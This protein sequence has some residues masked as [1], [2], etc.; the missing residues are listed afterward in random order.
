MPINLIYEEPAH[1]SNFEEDAYLQA[2]LD[3][4]A[5]VAAGQFESGWDHFV[6]F[7]HGE[8][9][10]LAFPDRASWAPELRAARA[11]K[12]ERFANA[13][14]GEHDAWEGAVHATVRDD[15]LGPVVYALPAD[16][17]S[18]FAVTHAPPISSWEYDEHPLSVINEHSDGLVLDCGAGFRRRYFENVINLEIVPYTSTDVVAVAERI[19]LSDGTV[20][21]VICIAVL[22][23]V[24]RPWLAASEI[25][26]VLRSGGDVYVA[27]P[28]LQPVHG[29]PNHFFNMTQSGLAS[30]FEGF[31]IRWHEVID[32]LHPIFALS[33]ILRSW[34]DGLSGATAKRFEAMRVADLTNAAETY[35]DE[36][37]VSEL[38][39]PKRFELAAGT[40]LLARKPA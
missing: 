25:R 1:W 6:R 28:F 13:L 15:G 22:E 20:D 8:D 10:C 19:P 23:H 3:V 14:I 24:K 9:R 40:A 27:V 36:P 31:D 30:L 29:Y 21:A 5:A 7:G 33:W 37:F 12:Y 35:L 4:A 2:N 18:E 11:A 39:A 32:W 26:R 17:G 34:R 38:S 16:V